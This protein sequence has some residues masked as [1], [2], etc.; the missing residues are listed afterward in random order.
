MNDITFVLE[1][2][3][4]SAVAIGLMALASRLKP[5]PAPLPP[6]NAVVAH[7]PAQPRAEFERRTVAELQELAR[8]QGIT[9]LSRLRKA[10]LID[11]L[12]A[13]AGRG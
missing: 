13:V 10:E 8:A 3:L 6:R 5:V 11:Q 9:G 4:F 1:A 12:L 2:L 7:P